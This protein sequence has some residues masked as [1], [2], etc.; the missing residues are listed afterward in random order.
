MKKGR[1]EQFWRTIKGEHMTNQ[2]E[3]IDGNVRLMAEKYGI[4]TLMSE[5]ERRT[6]EKE[7]LQAELYGNDLTQKNMTKEAILE[8]KK[9][10]ESMF[11][12]IPARLRK[13]MFADDVTK[14]ITK[15]TS[16][17][18]NELNELKKV[19]IISENQYEKVK[20][21]NKEKENRI[22]EEQTKIR[23]AEE[24]KKAEGDLYENFKKNGTLVIN[25]NTTETSD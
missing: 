7:S 3:A 15:Y 9:K 20:Q 18:L 13:E 22:K 17:D 25:K 24:M 4:E 19:G 14:F 10:L 1:K 21:Y 12:R 11:N 16:Q 5:A 2:S 23:F 8:S 6:I